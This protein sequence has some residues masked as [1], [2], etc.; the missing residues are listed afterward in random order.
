MKANRRVPDDISIMGIDD[1]ELAVIGDVEIT[2]IQHPME[3]LGEKTANNLIQLIKNRYF[4][5]NYE[6]NINIVERQS[7]K[8]INN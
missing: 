1:S 7:V 3:K 2:S 4:D 8:N 5:A 6:F